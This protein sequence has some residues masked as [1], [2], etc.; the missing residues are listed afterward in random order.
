VKI[1]YFAEIFP[2]ISETWVHHE[3]SQL[4]DMGCDVRVF[5][6]HARPTTIA[7][8]LSKFVALTTYLP[9]VEKS[10]VDVLRVFCSPAIRKNVLAGIITDCP[11]N[12]QKLQ[13]LRDIAIAGLFSRHL[14]AYRPEFIL[15][16]FGGTRANL[17]LIWSMVSGTRF[18]IKFHA[19]DV[20]ARVA[21]LRLKVKQ[22]AKLMTISKFNLSFMCEHY[23]DI[24]FA[25]CSVHKCGIPVDEYPFQ[26]KSMPCDSL[27]IMSTGRLVPM[28]GFPVLLRASR[29]LL[30]KGLSHKVKIYGDGPDR[31]RLGQLIEAMGLEANVEIMGHYDPNGI[32]TALLDADMFV[33]PAVFDRVERTMDGI[34][35]SLIEAMSVG[36]PVIST[37]ISGIPE[38][39]EH[40][41]NGY[42]AVPGDPESL[43]EAVLRWHCLNEVDRNQMLVAARTKIELDHD[44]Q[45]LSSVLKRDLL[46]CLRIAGSGKG[47]AE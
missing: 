7:P 6:T 43:A 16:H 3:I 29:R 20:F 33:L 1:A 2:S 35:V 21:L 41:V 37:T 42:L 24:D 34:P 13:V 27:V 9:E 12:R 8:E 46:G 39:I 30:E 28:K 17:A 4:I 44:V 18:G 14:A 11:Q 25:S 45:K 40:G 47:C 31:K 22:A 26:P 19:S 36:T 15:A 23:P 38:L 10:L 32:R 5:A